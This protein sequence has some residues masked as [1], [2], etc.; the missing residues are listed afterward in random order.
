MW[1]SAWSPSQ[2]SA[3]LRQAGTGSLSGGLGGGRGSAQLSLSS[4]RGWT[5]VFGDDARRSVTFSGNFVARSYSADAQLSFQSGVSS[6]TGDTS[7]GDG[8]FLPTGF[9]VHTLGALAGGTWALLPNLRARIQGRASS[10]QAPGRPDVT[11]LE[12]FGSLTYRFAALDLAIE[13]RYFTTRTAGGAING[14]VLMLRASRAFG[15]RY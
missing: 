2:C 4:S 10:S 1:I 11:F 3:A 6:L 5:P 15:S 7:V 9:D 14:N 13:D 8:I 12:G